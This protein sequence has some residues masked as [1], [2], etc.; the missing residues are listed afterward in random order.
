MKGLNY[1]S[2]LTY[3]YEKSQEDMKRILEFDGL[4][5]WQQND[6]CKIVEYKID[7]SMQITLSLL[8]YLQES[9]FIRLTIA[10]NIQL[11]LDILQKY[12]ELKK[13]NIQHN[14]LSSDRIL[15]NLTDIK[16]QIT[17][18]PERLLYTIHFVGYDC[19]FYEKENYKN[20]KKNDDQSIKEIIISITQLIRNKELKSKEKG[21]Q[22]IT[23]QRKREQKEKEFNQKYPDLVNI[24]KTLMDEGIFKSFDKFI[25]ASQIIF[26]KYNNLNNKNQRLVGVDKSFTMLKSK[27]GRRIDNVKEN[28]EWI[29]K[30]YYKDGQFYEFQQILQLTFPLIAKE[31]KESRIYSDQKAPKN[32]KYINLK[33]DLSNNKE[34][35]INQIINENKD[36]IMKDFKFELD[37]KLIK[38]DINSQLDNQL[39]ILN[40][41]LNDVKFSLINQDNIQQLDNILIRNSFLQIK[42]IQQH[43]QIQISELKQKIIQEVVITKLKIYVELQIM[44]VSEDML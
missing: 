18:M 3:S 16:H 7:H 41:F 30:Q 15:I 37:L 43:I 32:D 31:L 2:I 17:I 33:E 25:E 6:D 21:K 44:Q 35:F 8:L 9:K 28:L 10:Q 13:Q 29:Q 40:Y 34:E 20:S 23:D 38:D 22:L 1:S 14:Y 26:E 27:R 11:C 42:N 4:T 19:P 12:Q 39:K 5:N 36:E 24:F